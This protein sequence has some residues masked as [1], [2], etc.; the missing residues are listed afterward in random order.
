MITIIFET[1][2][3]NNIHICFIGISIED[4]HNH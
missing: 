3:R 1:H 4:A 2:P